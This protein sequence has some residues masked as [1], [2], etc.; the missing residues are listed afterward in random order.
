MVPDPVWGQPCLVHKCPPP[1]PE[2]SVN[3][4]E[5]RRL[6]AEMCY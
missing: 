3:D 4:M 2:G 6:L 1:Q 5:E